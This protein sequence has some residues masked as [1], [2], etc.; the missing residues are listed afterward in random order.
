MKQ[1]Y[2]EYNG[3]KYYSGTEFKIKKYIE[4]TAYDLAYFVYYDTDH[5][6]IWYQIAY[7][8]QRRG[9]PME[10]FLKCFQG[11]T[12]KVS[13]SIHPPIAKQLK[14]YQ[15]P[16]LFFG[17]VWYIALMFVAAI[18]NGVIIYWVVLSIF[19]FNWRKDVIKKEGYYVEW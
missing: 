14:D 17:W 9:M 12:G 18:L 6:T 10:K 16:A 8:N 3:V 11:I 4:S 1:N 19:F 7:T 5:D 15:I 2:F 13:N